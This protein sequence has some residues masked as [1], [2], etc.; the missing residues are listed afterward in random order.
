MTQDD[1]G[2]CLDQLI[3]KLS[4]KIG[5]SVVLGQNVNKAS[6]ILEMTVVLS[7]DESSSILLILILEDLVTSQ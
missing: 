4:E 6:V 2:N 7:R 3:E 1:E 5:T